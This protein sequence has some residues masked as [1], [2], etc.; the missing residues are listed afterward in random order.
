[1]FVFTILL[2]W[3]CKSFSNAKKTTYPCEEKAKRQQKDRHQYRQTAK[4]ALDMNEISKINTLECGRNTSYSQS[5]MQS[6]SKKNTQ[7]KL[8][9]KLTEK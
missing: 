3:Q 1:M 9:L 2:F 4:Q 8:S 5:F 6:D 7:R